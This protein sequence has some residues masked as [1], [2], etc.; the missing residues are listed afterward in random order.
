MRLK[1]KLFIRLF[2]KF[3]CKEEINTNTE[4]QTN[5]IYVFK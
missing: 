2:G 1:I 4:I 5:N 3:Q